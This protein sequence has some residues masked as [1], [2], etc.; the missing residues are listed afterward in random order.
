M[1]AKWTFLFVV[2]LA[3]T[4]IPVSGA[5]DTVATTLPVDRASD[6]SL[7]IRMICGAPATDARMA[8]LP[9]YS[10]VESVAAFGRGDLTNAGLA[11]LTRMPKLTTLAVGG[12]NL[13]AAGF[14][15][16]HGHAGLRSLTISQMTVDA[17]LG[18]WISSL[19]NLE[20]LHLRA[21]LT[22][23]QIWGRIANHP[24]IRDVSISSVTVTERE[25]PHLVRCQRLH[26]LYVAM[27]S[28]PEIV[29]ML[30]MKLRNTVINLP[31]GKYSLEEL[32]AISK[33]I[34]TDSSGDVVEV[35]QSCLTYATD[36]KMHVI[37]DF[38]TI[39]RLQLRGGAA[40]TDAGLPWLQSLKKLESLEL[41]STSVTDAGL[42]HLAALTGLRELNLR[43]P[44]VTE[45]G[46]AALRKSLPQCR[47]N[48][49]DFD[50][51]KLACP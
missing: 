51:G 12:R 32:G 23:E 40:L 39:V 11:F 25:V 26:Q 34:K 38:P 44:R 50:N 21:A 3:V 46:L 43:T 48:D 42:T 45:G 35:T 18:E 22:D 8:L 20:A 36:W 31:V 17:A 14:E 1:L 28:S 7:R 15:P 9:N 2:L 37:A 30:R 41:A 24:Q 16:L 47:I 5:D 10:E 49:H 19:P 6:G 29:H 27:P 4:G 13:T 33:S